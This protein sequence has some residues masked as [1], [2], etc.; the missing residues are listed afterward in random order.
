[1][2]DFDQS[3][4]Y[5]FLT[6]ILNNQISMDNGGMKIVMKSL[7]IIYIKFN[8]I[9]WKLF[10]LNKT[11]GKVDLLLIAKKTLLKRT[12][13]HPKQSPLSMLWSRF[14]W[15]PL[16]RVRDEYKF[17]WLGLVANLLRF[18]FYFLHFLLEVWRLTAICTHFNSLI[19]SV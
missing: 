1:M 7:W 13:Q 4:V 2:V 10:F 18:N 15:L 16:D 3:V 19:L 5:K 8:P 6:K 17:E 12:F 11:E 9:D 14:S